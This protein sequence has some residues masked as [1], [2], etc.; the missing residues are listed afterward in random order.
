[1]KIEWGTVTMD[2]EEVQ[3]KWTNFK[4]C[5][6]QKWKIEK[7]WANFS[8]HFLTKVKSRSHK[9]FKQNYHFFQIIIITFCC[10][11][12]SR[13]GFSVKPWLSQNSLCRLGWSQTQKSACLCLPSAGIKGMCHHTCLL[14]LFYS[15][16]VI[17][18]P[19]TPPPTHK[20]FLSPVHLPG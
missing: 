6:S 10:C 1:M 5:T 3:T 7:K 13:Q 8:I 20:K 11:C 2:I 15:L 19:V 4:I 12:F 16:V 17:P 14:L 9:K 18:L